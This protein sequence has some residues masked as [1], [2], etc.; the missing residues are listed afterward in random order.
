VKNTTALGP[1]DKTTFCDSDQ[2]LDEWPQL[3]GF[4]N[5]RLDPLMP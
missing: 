3:L 1:I 2:A 5:R 4:R